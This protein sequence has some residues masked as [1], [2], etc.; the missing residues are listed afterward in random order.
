[1]VAGT[2]GTVDTVGKMGAVLTRGGR[3]AVGSE[4][5]GIGSTSSELGNSAGR[6]AAPW[7]LVRHFFIRKQAMLNS[8]RSKRPSL[9]MSARFHM[10]PS[11]FT[12]RSDLRKKA[13]A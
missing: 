2:I 4:G 11:T 3:L 9:L 5:P 13:F 10:R 7:G 8:R 6:M 12:G 1:V